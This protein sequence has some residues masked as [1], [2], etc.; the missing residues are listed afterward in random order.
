MALKAAPSHIAVARLPQTYRI[1]VEARFSDDTVRDVTD[2]AVYESNRPHAAAVQQDGTL[3]V[4]SG[5]RH[6]VFAKFLGQ[7]ALVTV[8]AP[9]NAMDIRSHETDTRNWIDEYVMGS[10]QVVA[11]SSIATCRR[12]HARAPDASGF[13]GKIARSQLPQ[14]PFSILTTR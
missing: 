1:R 6:S 7:A 11:D 4:R 2:I 8:V 3:H 9:V 5:G 10:A 13:D 12:Q 14:Q